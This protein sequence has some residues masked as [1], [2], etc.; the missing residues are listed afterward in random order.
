[1]I[2]LLG[3]LGSLVYGVRFR[4]LP[5]ERT[6][7]VEREVIEMVAPPKELFSNRPDMPMPPLQRRKVK[8]KVQEL[9]EVD[10]PESRIIREVTVGGIA[11]RD[12]GTL[13]LTY[14]PDEAGPA[15]CPT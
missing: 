11:R 3:G 1:M 15:L 6:V 13:F 8:K 7:E 14:G 10:E 9:Q 2:L 5:V 12:D 4:F